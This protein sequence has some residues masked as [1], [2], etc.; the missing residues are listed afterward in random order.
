MRSPE[1]NNSVGAGLARNVF[2]GHAASRYWPALADDLHGR[3]IVAIA[4]V[5]GMCA[6]VMCHAI[7]G[8]QVLSNRR[9]LSPGLVPKAGQ[10]I[11]Q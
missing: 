7:Q 10:H 11:G 3:V 1:A 6:G 4:E 5:E 9:R 2:I 8:E